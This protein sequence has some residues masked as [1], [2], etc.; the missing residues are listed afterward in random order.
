MVTGPVEATAMGN[1]LTQVRASGEVAS[2]AEM[3]EVVRASSEVRRF[4]PSAWNE[5]SS[6]FADRQN[7]ERLFQRDRRAFSSSRVFAHHCAVRNEGASARA[8]Q[9]SATA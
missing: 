3:R 5:A 2:L 7:I 9:G 6:R 4:E 1:L 8:R